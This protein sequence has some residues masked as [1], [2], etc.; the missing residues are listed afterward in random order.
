MEGDLTWR[1]GHDDP[2]FIVAMDHRD[3]FGKTLFDVKNDDP[4]DAQLAA[5]KS[6]KRLIF[7]GLLEAVPM[8]ASGR[9]GVL[10]DEQYGQGVIDQ[11]VA[12]GTSVVLA[13]RSR[14]AAATGSPWSGAING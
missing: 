3:S 10:V 9:A 2:L 7:G 1:P 12:G 4:D 8:L 13:R 14:P 5:M 11:V 6:A